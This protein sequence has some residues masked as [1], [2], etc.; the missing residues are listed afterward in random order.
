MLNA[1][2]I[3]NAKFAKSMSGYK[4]EEVDILLD[5]VE[6]DYVQ[7]DRM[8]KEF[9]VKVDKLSQENEELKASQNSIQNVLLSAQTLADK[10]VN[11]AKE[12]SE[13]I[14]KNA[15]TNISAIT[16]HEKEL[17]SN[18]EAK[19]AERKAALEKEL[20]EMI[21]AAKFKAESVTK[22]AE[23]SVA[24]QQMLFDKLKIEIATFKAAV[25]AK[26]KE[27]LESLNSIPD[28]VPMDPEHIA[29]VVLAEIDKAP[30]PAQ[31]IGVE[32]PEVIEEP[33]VIEEA[34]VNEEEPELKGFIVDSFEEEEEE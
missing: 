30:N 1:A 8:I 9:Q 26:Y 31:F 20:G 33:A 14:I 32:E 24:R 21:A 7:F 25:N 10:I 13:E 5:K 18:F 6:A 17:A 16:A 11:E 4:Q 12:K 34:V 27:H 28:T 19:A 23:D 22:A 2:E 15:E 29:K 3:R